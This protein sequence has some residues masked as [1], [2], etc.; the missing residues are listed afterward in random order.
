MAPWSRLRSHVLSISGPQLCHR[1]LGRLNLGSRPAALHR[2][3][4]TS[5]AAFDFVIRFVYITSNINHFDSDRER[6]PHRD[7][8][9]CELWRLW[10]LQRL[11]R[12]LKTKSG[13][14]NWYRGSMLCQTRWLTVVDGLFGTTASNNDFDLPTSSRH[15][16]SSLLVVRTSCSDFN[17]Q[18]I[19][20][21][22]PCRSFPQPDMP[23]SRDCRPLPLAST[24]STLPTWPLNPLTSHT[25]CN[26][27]CLSRGYT[28]VCAASS[29]GRLDCSRIHDPN[30]NIRSCHMRY[31]EDFGVAQGS[32]EEDSR[33]R[34]NEWGEL[35]QQTGY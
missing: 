1:S 26:T 5:D 23:R 22:A 34:R 30:H 15:S 18:L 13:I 27:S 29:M 32:K 8:L 31:E 28:F 33:K 25:S 20:L 24:L 10:L 9:G 14:F 11:D 21:G 16:L 4:T 7:F 19:L 2:H 12:L 17:A 35:L 6:N 3:A